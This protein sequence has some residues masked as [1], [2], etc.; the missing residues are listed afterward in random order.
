MTAPRTIDLGEMVTRTTDGALAMGLDGRIVLWNH[1]A[2]TLLG[3]SQRDVIGSRC[4]E[5]FGGRDASGNLLCREGCHVME[6]ARSG[7]AVACFDMQ[8]STEAHRPVS[9]QVSTLSA[10]GGQDGGVLVVHLFRSVGAPE[11]SPAPPGSGIPPTEPEGGNHALTRRETE[12]LGLMTAGLGT[13]GIA[14]SLSVSPCTVRNHTQNILRKL[15]VHSRL[16]AV[17]HAARH[18]LF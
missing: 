10:S 3:H 1:A 14:A 5:V 12:I 7:G 9:L 18:R 4:W 15:G 13:R 2:E 8:S 16:E 11:K 6:Q 17:A